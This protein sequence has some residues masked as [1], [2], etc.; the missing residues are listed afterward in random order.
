MP[1]LRMLLRSPVALVLALAMAATGAVVASTAAA[2][3]GP[4]STLPSTSNGPVT[5]VFGGQ[6]TSDG[7]FRTPSFP[8]PPLE[9]VSSYTVP[10][11][12][13]LVVQSA[14]ASVYESTTSTY[15]G[16]P[17]FLKVLEV[18]VG[19]FYDLG[20]DVAY[21]GC[22]RNYEIAVVTAGERSTQATDGSVT[23]E[24]D[25]F[26]SLSGP[27]YVEG[28][29]VLS[30]GAVTQGPTGDDVVVLI[31]VHGTLEDAR[32]TPM[33]AQCRGSR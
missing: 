4:Q 5:L 26:G 7:S 16:R 23:Y 14:Y 25:S 22:Y 27:V 13:I 9:A 8:W 32:Y 2:S 29:R 30:G 21:P 3:A 20:P 10:R 11:Y 28:G 24:R 18:N 12:K 19:S 15:E 17:D 33:P 1:K 31:T 6:P